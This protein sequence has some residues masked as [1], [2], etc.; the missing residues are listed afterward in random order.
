[1]EGNSPNDESL[2]TVVQVVDGGLG[3]AVAVARSITDLPARRHH[4]VLTGSH[5]DDRPV[6]PKSP[7]VSI[8]RAAL[9]RFGLGLHL[10]GL[11]RS[12]GKGRILVAHRD[13]LA[14][15]A[16]GLLTQTPVIFVSH[17]RP[18]VRTTRRRRYAHRLVYHGQSF[19]T[20]SDDARVTL[21]RT[22]GLDSVVIENGVAIPPFV[23]PPSGEPLR[24]VYLGRFEA[25]QKRPD[26][27]ILVT[28]LL[29]RRG[30]DVQTV[31]LGD[32][33]LA[34]N[35]RSLALEVGVKDRI[36]FAGWVNDPR[37]YL[38]SAHAVLHC[39]RWEG[40]PLAALEA[41]AAGRPVV[42]NGVPGTRFLGGVRGV[43]LVEDDET[44]AAVEGFARAVLRIRELARTGSAEDYY[45]SIQE[46][47]QGR[48][49]VE[50]M[51]AAWRDLLGT[52]APRK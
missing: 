32:G 1:M 35:L 5:L 46:A 25:P 30:V 37:P 34:P 45:R 7:T 39:A 48:F 33:P 28:S 40:N 23:A 2:A 18:D 21:R 47:A 17:G 31:M 3:G 4:L 49:S 41:L 27:P 52:G 19:V 26:I 10:V 12:F 24:L 43:D 51:L 16:A 29:A 50:R 13:W 14:C 44:S 9:E 42:A 20:V 38:E 22:L 15:R 8:E 11:L 6:L 36:A